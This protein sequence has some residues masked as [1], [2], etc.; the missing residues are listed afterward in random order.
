MEA[1]Y[2]ILAR[3][4]EFA[5]DGKLN[6][7]GGDSD[8]IV[9]DSYPYVHNMIIAASRLLLDKK[10]AGIEHSFRAIIVD[11]ETDEIIAEG[12]RGMLPKV[13][14]PE[15]AERLG[16]GFILPFRNVVFPRDGRYLVKLIVDDNVL[17]KA[18]FRVA[19]S[20]YYQRLT[21]NFQEAFQ[22]KLNDGSR[23]SGPDQ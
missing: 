9:A 19:P 12:A 7:L 5:P 2:L 15:G 4:A 17:G 14:F 3:Y 23:D 21:T 8:Q 22:R 18:P 1:R 13:P 10:D 16:S 20:A 6:L 11:E